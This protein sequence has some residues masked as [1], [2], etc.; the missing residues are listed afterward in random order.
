MK[1]DQ[2]H[3]DTVSIRS[4]PF[5]DEGRALLIDMGQPCDFGG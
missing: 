1:R 3:D 5:P 4:G 2:T